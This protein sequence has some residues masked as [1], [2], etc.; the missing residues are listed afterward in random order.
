VLGCTA[1]AAFIAGIA[2]FSASGAYLAGFE[3]GF[4]RGRA[5]TESLLLLGC[6]EQPESYSNLRGSLLLFADF[7]GSFLVSR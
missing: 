6:H 2:M 7:C 3:S 1:L 5:Q 4:Q